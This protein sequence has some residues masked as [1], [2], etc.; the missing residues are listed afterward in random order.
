MTTIHLIRHGQTHWNLER[1][2]QG[3]TES[4]LTDLGRQ[5]A[6]DA[7]RALRDI[8]FDCAYASS[9]ERA[10]D[11]ALHILEYHDAPLTLDDN[12]REI[13]LGPWEGQLYEDVKNREPEHYHHFWGDVSQ[14]NLP[15]AE[16]FA[17]IQQRAIDTLSGIVG[18]EQG[19]TILVVSHG[20]WIKSVLTALE[21]RPLPDFWQPPQMTNC[22]HSIIKQNDNNTEQFPDNFSI[23]QYAGFS[24]WKKPVPS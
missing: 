7:G 10:R 20:I 19:K 1:R 21:K 4:T 23:L 13:Y 16:T 6:S 2:V 9:S 14:F 12:I 3:Q 24:N 15:G 5:Q 18:K 11:T 8:P 17:G 22:C